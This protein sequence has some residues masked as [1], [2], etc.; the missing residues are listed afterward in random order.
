[1]LARLAEVDALRHID[2][3]STVSGGSIVGAHYYLLLRGLLEQKENPT[4]EEYIDLVDRSQQQLC[5]GVNK[6]LHMRGLSNPRI[7]LKLLFETNYTRGDRM[8]E[9]YDEQLFAQAAEAPDTRFPLASL[10]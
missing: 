6:N 7:T 1:V 3:L 9:L 2:V 4:R 10:A 5:L 8:A